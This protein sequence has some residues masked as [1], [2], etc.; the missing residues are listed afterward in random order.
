VTYAKRILWHDPMTPIC[1]LNEDGSVT[2]NAEF[3]LTETILKHVVESL[4]KEC[5]V[6][7]QRILDNC[8]NHEHGGT[9][10]GELFLFQRQ[11]TARTN[12]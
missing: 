4:V 10:H 6:K 5:E 3:Q 11:K 1:T 9:K 7:R 8:T 2:W 12:E